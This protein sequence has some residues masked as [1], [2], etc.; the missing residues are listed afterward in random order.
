MGWSDHGLKLNSELSHRLYFCRCSEGMKNIF[1]EFYS[2]KEYSREIFFTPS[3]EV[4]MS[5]F[6]LKWNQTA[7]N[8]ALYPLQ[9]ITKR[10][11]QYGKL[12]CGVSCSFR[13][14]KSNWLLP[15]GKAFQHTAYTIKNKLWKCKGVLWDIFFNQILIISYKKKKSWELFR[16]CLINSTANPAHF[17]PTWAV[18]AVLI[19]RHLPNRSRNLFHIFSIIFF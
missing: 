12:G 11:L 9:L 10:Y 13:D 6:G 3:D 16:I 8:N 18:L 14:T 2:K 4:G 5:F 1:L 15:K 7:T 17:H 19:S